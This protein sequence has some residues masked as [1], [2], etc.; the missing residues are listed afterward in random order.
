MDEY[1]LEALEAE[2]VD[3]LTS[4][5]DRL[6]LDADPAAFKLTIDDVTTAL[7]VRFTLDGWL[8]VA[9]EIISVRVA[10]KYVVDT[11]LMRGL[12]DDLPAPTDSRERALHLRKHRNTGPAKSVP[13]ARRQWG[14]S[15]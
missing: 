12:I 6:G 1:L 15:R 3:F 11:V 4:E 2:H 9:A 13:G 5:L 10:V 14:G 8:R 7:G